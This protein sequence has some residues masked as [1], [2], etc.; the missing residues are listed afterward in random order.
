MPEREEHT[1]S[2]ASWDL[3]S[4]VVAGRR[5]TL[6]VGVACSSGCNLTGTR[7]DV[8]NETG[9]R[10]GG[11]R[12]GSQPW[13][14]TTALHWVELDVAAPDAE[15]D[16]A[17]S[18]QATTPLDQ[19][20]GALSDSRKAEPPHVHAASTVRFV[21]V[22]TPEHRVTIEVIEKGSG[23]PLTRVELRVGR[24]RA[25]TTDGGIAHV[26]VPGGTYEVCA[27]K[28]G[29][30]LLSST[31]HVSGDTTIHLEVE[32]APAPEQPYWM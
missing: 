13:P 5:A 15:G 31:V 30:D 27:W 24:F 3:A 6:K 2:L 4:P 12:L 32:V 28:I 14:A 25:A 1:T 20:R 22:R 9:T 11:G 19:A 18:L 17:W 21:A 7:I 23:V 26:E 16:H 29:Y 8:Y 10:V